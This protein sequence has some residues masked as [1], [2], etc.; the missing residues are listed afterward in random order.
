ML[1]IGAG[2]S[3][4]ETM[5]RIHRELKE[6][7]PDSSLYEELNYAV[8][9]LNAGRDEKTVYTEM[10]R[11]TGVEEYSRLMTLICRNIERG[12]SN[13]LELL[14]REEKDAFGMRKNRAKKKGE[15]AAEKLLLPM[16][17]LLVAV[18]GIVMFPALKNF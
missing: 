12:N 10:G 16:F 9:G 2:L 3:V 4:K 15:E 8:N 18:V 6:N 14:R 5:I 1:R 17:I 7:A 11:S 13:L